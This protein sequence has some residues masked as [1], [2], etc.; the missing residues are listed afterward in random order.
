MTEPLPSPL[1]KSHDQWRFQVVMKAVTPRRIATHIRSV[2]K[3][4]TFPED[5]IVT[6]DMDCYQMS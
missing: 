5:V 1:V 3:D 2:M 6:F 4:M